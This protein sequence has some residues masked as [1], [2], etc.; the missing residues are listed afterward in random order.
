[1]SALHLIS[2][3]SNI[4]LGGI[5][6]YLVFKKRIYTFIYERRDNRRETE[7]LRVR[8]VVEEVLQEILKDDN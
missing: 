8:K 2:I 6:V 5:L 7:R 1:M 4:L 3:L